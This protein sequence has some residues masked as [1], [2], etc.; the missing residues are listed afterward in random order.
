VNR[1]R[2]TIVN[3]SINESSLEFGWVIVT[4]SYFSNSPD[5]KLG[6]LTQSNE[7]IRRLPG[8]SEDVLRAI[9]ILP[10]VARVEAR[11]NDLIVR[12]GAPSEN[13]FIVDG[14][15]AQNINHFG[16]QGSGG[17][18]LSYINLDYVDQTTFST[19][20]FGVR[21][22]DKLSSVLNIELKDDNNGGSNLA[23]PQLL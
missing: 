10:G 1:I 11:R 7:E 16:T 12:G 14:I 21:Y 19:G 5:L 9:S 8:G 13:L 22:G 4:P 15:E 17:G 18:P 20:G 2:S 6:T 23:L 3:F